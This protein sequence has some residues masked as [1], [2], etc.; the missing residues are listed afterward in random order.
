M[1]KINW[2]ICLLQPPAAVRYCKRCGRKTKFRSSGL[3]RV[4]A[5]QKHLDVWLIY[6]CSVCD[7]T[8]NLSI[9]SGISPAGLSQNELH[10]YL[11]ND[12]EAALRCAL[13]A[14]LL[15]KS[16]AAATLPVV[17]TE[18][19]DGIY[20]EPFE[21]HIEAKQAVDIKPEALLRAKLGLSRSSYEK[22]I[23]HGRI[24]C[25]SGHNLKKCRLHGTM[26]IQITP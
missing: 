9:H 16:G 1:K 21:L 10:G 15:K 11:N 8:W 22:L 5:H 4:N 3:F 12:T 24:S 19:P 23:S 17:T 13:N 18:G 26:I 25:I 20:E 6:K 2:K 14:D 7:T